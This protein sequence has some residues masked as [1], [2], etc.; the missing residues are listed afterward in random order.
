M[1][2]VETCKD[3]VFLSKALCMQE[4]CAKPAWQTYPACVK[5]KEEARMREDSRRNSPGG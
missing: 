1:E 5:L 4:E 3:K 2:P